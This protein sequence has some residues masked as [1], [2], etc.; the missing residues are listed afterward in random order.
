MKTFFYP[1]LALT[2]IKKNGKV[3]IPY[4]LTSAFTV[5]MFYLIYSLSVNSG[6]LKMDAGAQ[7]MS[8]ILGLGVYVVI[9]FSVIFLFYINS[10]IIKRRK[11]EVA[12]YNILGV[13]KKHV[14]IMMFCETIV[15]TLISLAGGILL[16]VLF[17][18]LMFLLLV[19]LVGFSTAI[20]I[21]ISTDAIVK[22]ILI[23]TPIFMVSYL[24]NVIQIKL[25]NP[26]ELLRGG[27]TGEKE[28]KTKWLLT[29]IG[30]FTLGGGYFIA[31]TI[32]DP[33]TAIL[34]F[35]I[36]VILVIIGTYCLFTA[37]SIA[38]LKMLKANK[39]FYYQTKHFTS[40]SQLIYRM[41][42][43]AVGLASICILCTCILV[44]LS[45]TVS[46]YSGVQDTANKILDESF[47]LKFYLD[48]DNAYPSDKDLKVLYA[49]LEQQLNRND[50]EYTDFVNRRYV[51]VNM[52]SNK[53]NQVAL[54]DNYGKEAI[55]VIGLTLDE[56]NRAYHDNQKLTKNE[57]IMS[58]NYF[59]PQKDFQ[60]GKHSFAVKETVHK[61]FL[62]EHEKQVAGKEVAVVFPDTQTLEK[63]LSVT[64]E[65]PHMNYIETLSIQ[66]KDESHAEKA[67]EVLKDCVE[68][69]VRQS[70]LSSHY[71]MESHYSIESMLTQMYGSLFFL[72]I[73][74]G[75][76]FLMA[77]ILI[78][79]YKQLS[80]GY[81]D[82]KRFEIM[83]NVGMSKKEVKQTI[84]SQVLIFFFLPLIVAVIHMA[85]AFKMI[86]NMFSFLVLSGP[87]VF[88]IC[89]AISVVVLTIIY[90]IVYILTARTYY[91]IVRH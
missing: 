20:S 24:F 51:I 28:P 47:Q 58:S 82:Q 48:D 63:T 49:K 56:Y 8:M 64:P 54:S 14:M 80:E 9:I 86:V 42:Q 39:H 4:L 1:R 81:E 2:N 36:A 61:P 60:I 67:N 76:L 62:L 7:T 50:I 44:M 53:A 71:Y 74:L 59:Q 19:K 79:Y 6:V 32:E 11:K 73:F 46:L 65:D 83:Q 23:Y 26:I 89:T 85:F 13:E 88:I 17:S 66:Y 18:K 43:N 30:V 70:E 15:T 3:Y 45:S 55:T 38:I 22:T 29:I 35:F 10:F 16:G 34:L 68:N 91:K 25:A 90:S 27:Q 52:A 12:L 87:E 57:I 72:G 37:G 33:A 21:G 5:M 31:Q 77:A 78:M 75:V 84:R 41:K 69:E 40:V